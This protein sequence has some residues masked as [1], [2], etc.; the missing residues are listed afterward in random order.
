MSPSDQYQTA[1]ED[2]LYLEYDKVLAALEQAPVALL[3]GGALLTPE[4]LNQYFLIHAAVQ[5]RAKKSAEASLFQALRILPE[6][7]LPTEL[8]QVVQAAFLTAK[9]AQ[10][11]QPPLQ[12]RLQAP[13]STR[14]INSTPDGAQVTI[15]GKKR[16]TPVEAWA[17]PAGKVMLTLRFGDGVE[18]STQA[19]LEAGQTLRCLGRREQETFRC[20]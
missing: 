11:R 6:Q 9:D 20:R 17:F 7:P 18:L 8:P 12:I 1:Y 19:T 13:A 10:L 5:L 2:L 4:V 3:C 15:N 16:V 14:Y